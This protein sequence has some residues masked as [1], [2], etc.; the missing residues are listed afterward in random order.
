MAS[1]FVCLQKEITLKAF[2]RGCHLIGDKIKALDEVKKVKI[3]TCHVL[4]KTNIHAYVGENNGY[5][6]KKI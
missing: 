2:K 6:S 4:S 5:L 1:G 3:G